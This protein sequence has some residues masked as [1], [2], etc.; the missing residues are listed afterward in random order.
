MNVLLTGPTGFIGQ[1]IVRLLASG[2]HRLF[3]LVRPASMEKAKKLFSGIENLTF[4]EGDIEDT[5][6]IK[7]IS[8]IPK[9]IG[10]ID[11]LV[12][13]AAF[14][15][16]EASLKEAYLK[17]VIGTQNVL[18]LASRMK[19]LK[20]F[21][22]F[23]TYA[24]NPVAQGAVNEDFLIEG[25]LPFHDEYAKTKNHAE[26]LVRKF[27][28]DGVKTVIYRPGI[29]IGDSETGAMDKTDG[30]YYLYDF[31]EKL[32][33]FERIH[34]KFPYLP[35]PIRNNTILPVLPVDVLAKWCAH[36]ISNPPEH[37]LRCYHMVPSPAIKTKDF[38]ES[39]ME[40]LGLPLKIFPVSQTRLFKP[41]LPF[42]NIPQEAA[43]YMNQQTVFDRLHLQTD[44][45][46]LQSP[47]PQQYLPNIIE[48]YLKG[49][50]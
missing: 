35:M 24:V 9:V 39:S 34:S 21:H 4:I 45:P 11:V 14:Y 19:N 3:L 8:T 5:D 33:N 46:D 30:P 18:R 50:A 36:I 25:D 44:Y 49:R 38:L 32:K 29:V 48:G 13:M 15:K 31:V 28:H 12:H 2:G 27:K 7:S 6:V 37:E 42:M 40:L 26:H 17:N 1:R 47:H 16:L 22:Y 20:H 23:S 43:F 41:F 10:D